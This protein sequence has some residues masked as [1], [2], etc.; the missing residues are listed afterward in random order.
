MRDAVLRARG[1]RKEF[2]NGEARV[3]TVDEVD[4]AVASGESVAV[5]GPSG[6]GK[7]TLL[8]LL[9]RLLRP[10]AGEIE[11]AGHRIH[12][13][14]ERALA[15]LRSDQVGF[16]FQAF[17][18]MPELTAVENVKVPALLAGQPSRAGD[19]RR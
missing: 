2:G 3:R 15:Q 17:H 12:A 9:G 13:M 18:L 4:L 14:N 10:S 16:V 6:R 7:S 5:M 1:V 19:P 8:H 11:F